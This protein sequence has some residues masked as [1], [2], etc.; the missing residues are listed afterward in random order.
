MNLKLESSYE[1]A[2]LME[3]GHSPYSIKWFCV[4]IRSGGLRLIHD[5]QQITIRDA[6]ISP[7]VD[8]FEKGQAKMRCFVCWTLTR[9]SISVTSTRVVVI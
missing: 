3:P 5:M 2:Q 1:R 8:E 6:C 7:D 9:A 4:R